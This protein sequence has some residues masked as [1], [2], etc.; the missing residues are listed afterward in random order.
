MTPE[1]MRDNEYSEIINAAAR[2]NDDRTYLRAEVKELRA[3]VEVWKKTHDATATSAAG[4]IAVLESEVELYK[5]ALGDDAVKQQPKVSL[6][7]SRL[8]TQ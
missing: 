6:L 8:L 5:A 7:G 3:E 4:R 2:L 1:K